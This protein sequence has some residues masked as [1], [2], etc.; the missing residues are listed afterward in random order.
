MMM[1]MGCNILEGGGMVV[2]AVLEVE[3]EVT[4]SPPEAHVP[5]VIY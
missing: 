3:D 2:D 1:A 4:R 5:A